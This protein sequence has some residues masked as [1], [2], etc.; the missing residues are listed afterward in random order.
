M[1]FVNVQLQFVLKSKYCL[2]SMAVFHEAF[3]LFATET[4]Y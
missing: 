1:V 3:G 4:T 2:V